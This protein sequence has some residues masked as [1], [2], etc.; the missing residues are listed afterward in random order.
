MLIKNLEVDKIILSSIDSKTRVMELKVLFSNETPLKFTVQLE[1]DFDILISKMIKR[2]KF[3][4]IPQDSDEDEIL[5]GI[6]VVNI[7]NE[8]DIKD[9]SPKRL[10]MI[11]QRLTNLKKTKDAINYMRLYSQVSTM[12]D[13][14][15]TKETQ[16]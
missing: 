7:K 2:I 5:G 1:E 10:F 3:L 9:R 16:R 4:K 14:V 12:E 8:E 13:I 15:Y 6:T 11:D